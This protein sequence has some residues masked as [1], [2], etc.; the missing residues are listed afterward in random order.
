MLAIYLAYIILAD[1]LFISNSSYCIEI[2]LTLWNAF[3]MADD[4]MILIVNFYSRYSNVTTL[5][6]FHNYFHIKRSVSY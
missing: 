5:Q 3:E 4:W 2:G 1:F 6:A